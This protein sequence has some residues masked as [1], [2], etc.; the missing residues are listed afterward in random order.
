MRDPFSKRVVCV[1]PF[2]S[3]MVIGVTIKKVVTP[4]AR[5]S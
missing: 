4:L 5:W 3:L 2:V 1:T